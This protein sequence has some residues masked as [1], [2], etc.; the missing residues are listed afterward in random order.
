MKTS[1][2]FV[3]LITSYKYLFASLVLD[4]IQIGFRALPS[5]VWIFQL[6]SQQSAHTYSI[7]IPATLA[8]PHH[9][10]SV[11]SLLSQ[12]RQDRSGN[13]ISSFITMSTSQ[14]QFS[15]TAYQVSFCDR[16]HPCFEIQAR[17]DQHTISR[18]AHIS[19]V[20]CMYCCNMMGRC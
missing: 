20:S 6:A 9:C 8:F 19:S 11:C 14:L 1:P 17:S 15:G 4:I 5:L 7:Y 2:V 18:T 3:K 12:C 10:P 16:L 13:H